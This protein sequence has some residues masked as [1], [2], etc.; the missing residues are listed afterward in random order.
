LLAIARLEVFILGSSTGQSPRQRDWRGGD[1]L[2]G[3]ALPRYETNAQNDKT[4]GEDEVT[5]ALSLE[6]L[7]QD[8]TQLREKILLN[9]GIYLSPKI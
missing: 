1:N 4:Y 9:R 3:S 6:D 2:E 8:M 5:E 7:V